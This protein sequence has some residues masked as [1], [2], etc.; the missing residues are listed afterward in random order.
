MRHLEARQDVPRFDRRFFDGRERFTAIGSGGH[1]GKAAGL[2]L[3][4]DVLARHFEANRFPTIDVAIP[5]L[6]V[7]TT[8]HFDRFMVENGLLDLSRSEASDKRIALAFQQADLPVELL[9]DLRAL[10]QTV[11]TPLAIRSSS[12]LED[13]LYRPFAGV[14]ATK[15]IPNNQPDADTRFRRLVEAVK[16]VYASTFFR[17]AKRYVQAAGRTIDDEKMAVII[18]EVVGRRH[19]ERFYPDIAGVGRSYSFYRTGAA[20]PE[21][22]V[23]TLALG[24][25]R[26]IVDEGIGWSYSP[27]YPA[28]APPYGS[29]DQLLEQT[30][31]EFWAVNMGRPPAYDPINEIEHLVRCSITDAENDGALRHL[32]STFDPGRDRLTVGVSAH[33]PR[34]LD[35]APILQL[36]TWPLNDALQHLLAVCEQALESPV[37]VEFAVTLDDGRARLGFLQVRPMVVSRQA[38][39][40]TEADLERP[41]AV[42]ASDRV[43]GN[44]VVDAIRDIVYVKPDRFEAR[45]TR[46][47]AEE[48]GAINRA[49]A[50]EGRPYLLLGFGRW[51]SADPWLG[52]PV[53]WAEIAGARAIVEA[54]LPAMNVELSQGSHFFH[55]ISSFDVSYFSVRHDTGGRIAW[56]WLAAQPAVAETDLVRHVRPARPIVVKVDGRSGRGVILTGSEGNH[57]P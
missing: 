15:M 54:S 25:G 30:Q 48:L 13:A 33:G 57:T 55:N 6:T 5:T 31:T 4:R 11:H 32:A 50:D 45:F 53:T 36:G 16:F 34:V 37:E 18:Q 21:E 42:V 44:G 7:V 23:V 22:G 40:V 39:D 46:T 9:G 41:D 12:L 3:M 20:R 43:M 56:A 35:F 52:I 19:R 28:V 10:I 38:V 49:L 1:G 8:E 29:I 27:A 17:D 47:I 51:G 14:Y 2:L 24:L 26:T